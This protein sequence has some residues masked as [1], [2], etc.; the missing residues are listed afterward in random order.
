[1][2]FSIILL[3]TYKSFSLSIIEFVF[4]WTHTHNLLLYLIPLHQNVVGYHVPSKQGWNNDSEILLIKGIKC[5]ISWIF[6]I[7]WRSFLSTLTYNTV[8]LSKQWQIF[9]NT[10]LMSEK[11]LLL[12][13]H[14]NSLI[15]YSYYAGSLLL[16]LWSIC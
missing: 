3:I 14:L 11:L 6:T 9:Q 1:M 10:H 13:L 12:G 4:M 7:K 2:F 16:N 15:S 5:Y 8:T